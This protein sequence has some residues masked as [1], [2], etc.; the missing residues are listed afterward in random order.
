MPTTNPEP[1]DKSPG[2]SRLDREL[3]EILAK[4]DNIRHLPPPPKA[5]RPKPSP[6]SMTNHLGSSIPAPI[7]RVLR[8]PIFQALALGVVA[9]LV[10]DVSPLAAYLLSI[11]AVACIILPIVSGFRRPAPTLESR[12]WRGRVVDQRPSS[13]GPSPLDSLRRWW[14][15]RR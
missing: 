8:V 4:N 5:R 10:D 1:P 2:K 7:G 11:A 3:E 12:M 6:A 15:T 9:V 13:S 14:T